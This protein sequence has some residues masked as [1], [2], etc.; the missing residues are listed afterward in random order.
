MNVLLL[1]SGGRENA[2]AWI[3]QKST[4]L[5]KLFIAP[6]NHGT[7]LLGK[8]IKLDISNFK[9]IKEFIVKEQIK[10]LIVGPEQPI[11]EGIYDY[12]RGLFNAE[13]LII[14]APSKLGGALEGSKKFAKEFMKKYNIPNA[15]YRTF[16]KNKFTEAEEYLKTLPPPYVLKADGLAAGKGVVISNN[17]SEAKNALQKMLIENQFGEASNTVLI[18][19]FLDGIELSVFVLTNGKD[20]KI[21]PI[22]KDYKR[23]GEGNTGLNTGGM[24]S[25]SPPSFVDKTLMKKIEESIIKPTIQGLQKENIAYN[26]FIFFGLINVNGEPKVIEYN[27]RLGDPETQSV[28]PRIKSDFL[29]LLISTKNDEEFRNTKIEVREQT[30]ISTI[31]ASKGYPEKYSTGHQIEGLTNLSKETILFHSG[32]SKKENKILTT[33]GRVLAVTSFGDNLTTAKKSNTQELSKISFKGMVY[34]ADIGFDLK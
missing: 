25:V 26:G 20:Y 18:E 29:D 6:G 17:V 14:I 3:I 22:A 2:I 16:N 31:L 23:I 13:E 19:E 34:R 11:V 7:S 5:N 32:T 21:L 33:G 27:A 9:N 24:G 4:K 10:L 12:L 30:C 1:G 8:N 28:L 15:K